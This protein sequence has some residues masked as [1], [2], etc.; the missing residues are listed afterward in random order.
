MSEPFRQVMSRIKINIEVKK[1]DVGYKY[2]VITPI[3]S[4]ET[5]FKFGEEIEDTYVDGRKY[6]VCSK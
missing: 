2:K 1:T 4:R 3:L 6:K 5:A